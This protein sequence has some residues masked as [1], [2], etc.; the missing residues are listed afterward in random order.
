MGGR[1]LAEGRVMDYRK[2]GQLCRDC[3]D[4][5]VTDPDVPAPE[6]YLSSYCSSSRLKYFLLS[7]IVYS[8][9]VLLTKS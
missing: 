4:C 9:S 5:T 6:M 7:T 2:R 3:F 8:L 1:N